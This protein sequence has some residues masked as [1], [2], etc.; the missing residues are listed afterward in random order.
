MPNKK[1]ID[2]LKKIF[3]ENQDKR[4]CVVATSCAGKS[5]LVNSFSYALD[6]DKELFP[7]LTK[8]ESD[9]VCQ[10]WTE[11]IGTFMDNLARIKLKIKPKHPIFA[12]VILD[13]DLI[14]FLHIS[15]DILKERCNKRGADFIGCW[16]MQEKIKAELQKCKQEIIILEL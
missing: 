8:E 14:V 6:M 12:T 3:E 1:I 15:E 5:T 13:A 4:I 9:Y 2:D 10:E 16:K 11:E 7:L